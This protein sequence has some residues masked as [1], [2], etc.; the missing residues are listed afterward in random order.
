MLDA[1]QLWNCL[2]YPM[3][4]MMIIEIWHGPFTDVLIH[5]SAVLLLCPLLCR[6]FVDILHHL[7]TPCNEYRAWFNTLSHSII[8]ISW[9]YFKNTKLC[10]HIC[11]RNY[12][13]SFKDIKKT[14]NKTIKDVIEQFLSSVVLN[15]FI[16][17]YRSHCLCKRLVGQNCHRYWLQPWY[18]YASYQ[19]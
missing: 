2:K 7:Q 19:G 17:K 14:C 9:L 16:W 11:S 13:K 3:I 1:D 18:C 10:H 5:S 6:T 4:C 15:C 12:G 8:I